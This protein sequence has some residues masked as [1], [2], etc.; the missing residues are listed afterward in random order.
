MYTYSLTK[1]KRF[2]PYSLPF[3]DFSLDLNYKTLKSSE[4]FSMDNLKID[5][6][7]NR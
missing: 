1:L 4:K 2:V 7:L 5:N 6:Y 3:M